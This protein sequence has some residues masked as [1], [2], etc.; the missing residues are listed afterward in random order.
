MNEE[1]RAETWVRNSFPSGVS[2]EPI[3]RIDYV[4]INCTSIFRS[5]GDCELPNTPYKGRSVLSQRETQ[6]YLRGLDNQR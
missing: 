1:E 2:L 6:K 3:K 5:L 4:P